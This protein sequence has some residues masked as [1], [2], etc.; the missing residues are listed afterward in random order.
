M[1]LNFSLTGWI[2]ISNMEGEKN[3][4]RRWWWGY[5]LF[6]CGDSNALLEG[7]FVTMDTRRCIMQLVETLFGRSGDARDK[8]PA[9]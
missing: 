3:S 5:I 2:E 7:G 6:C 1:S 8:D 4:W 9:F